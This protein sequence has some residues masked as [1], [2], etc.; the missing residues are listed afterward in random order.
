MRKILLGLFS[1]ISFLSFAQKKEQLSNDTIKFLSDLNLYF[2]D[3][4]G[5][6]F[7]AEGYLKDFFS[8]WNENYIAGYWKEMI[9]NTSN[10]MANK[11]LKPNPFFLSYFNIIYN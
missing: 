10:M 1:I 3:N 8:K 4:T 9:I 11:R 7:E 5:S 6:R 2:I